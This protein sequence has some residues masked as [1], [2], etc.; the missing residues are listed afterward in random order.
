MKHFFFS[1]FFLLILSAGMAQ[2]KELLLKNGSGG[3]YLEHTV[4]AKQGLFAIGRLYNVH[5]RHI[6]AFNQIDFN[7]G[8]SIGQVLRIPLTD[9]NFTQ[10]AKTDVPVL[11]RAG[12]GETL[13]RISQ[14]ANKIPVET[15][16]QWNGISGDNIERGT[17]L[18]V[19]FILSGEIKNATAANEGDKEKPQLPVSN[20]T[21]ENSKPVVN[22]EAAEEKEIKKEELPG[23][24]NPAP[25]VTEVVQKPS[26]QGYFRTSFEYQVN[27]KA[28]VNEKTVV[29]GIFKT[30]SGWQDAKYYALADNVEPG[31]VIK[32]TNPVNGKI[33]YAKV[34]GKMDDLNPNAGLNIRISNSAASVLGIPENE[35][36][37][38]IVKVNY[39]P[40]P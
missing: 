2:K 19:G 30:I 23:P 31:T 10:K 13:S 24:K 27:Q 34:L 7:K 28:A 40:R 17:A 26:Q 4:E 29:S 37:K 15:L 6:A 22:K 35:T 21:E 25:A 18:V 33:V 36:E 14:N 32:I 8:L 20:N 38:F 12:E 11:Y 9:T 1:V 16:R 39:I 5:P 3:I